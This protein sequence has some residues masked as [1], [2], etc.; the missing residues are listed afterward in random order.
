M[1]K[2]MLIIFSVFSS[3][4]SIYGQ[5]F[6]ED[7]MKMKAAY[8]GVSDLYMEMENSVWEEKT[9]AKEQQVVIKKKGAFYLYELEDAAMLINSKYILMIDHVGKTIVYDDWTAEKASQLAQ[10]HIPIAADILKKYPS[11]NYK[12]KINNYKKYVLKNENIQMSKVEVLFEPQTGFMRAI[13]YYY[14]PKLVE[15]EVYTELKMKVINIKPSFKA[16]AFSEKQFITQVGN[17]FKG[18]GKY[19]SY[20]VHSAK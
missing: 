15:K 9:V 7:M 16:S 18:I 19:S 10:Q 8:E 4:I 13:R 14:N 3:F 11:I 1:N 20:A 17:Q 2:L 6:E 5:S 12:G